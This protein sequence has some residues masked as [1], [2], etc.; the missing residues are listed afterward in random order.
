V[1]SVEAFTLIRS[2]LAYPKGYYS[3]V[4]DV[5][6]ALRLWSPRQWWVAAM[7]GV[8]VALIVAIPTAVIPN[9]VFGRSIGVTWWSYPI[10]LVT[11]VLGGLLVA[12]Y[13]REPSEPTADDRAGADQADLDGPGRT[14]GVAG[15]LS[16]FA[17]GC[18]TCNKQEMPCWP[19]PSQAGPFRPRSMRHET[20]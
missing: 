10:L 6:N 12:T 9:P 17:V 5:V 14:G 16:F 8:I 20:E 2:V 19:H 1:R 15:L 3:R 4:T 13:V 11:A 7:G 18:P